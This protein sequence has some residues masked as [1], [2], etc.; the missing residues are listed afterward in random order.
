MALE[1]GQHG[2]TV[3][4]ICPGYAR[5]PIVESQ[6]RDQANYHDIAE[7][8]VVDQIILAPAAIK[9]LIEPDE[10]SQLALFLAS[11]NARSITG[12]A[13]SIDAGWVAR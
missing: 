5:T 8:E 1:G 10:I 9:Q 13:Y 12:S 6:I 7:D 3:N 11:E 4:A 2:I